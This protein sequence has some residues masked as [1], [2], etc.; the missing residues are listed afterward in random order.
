MVPLQV[1]DEEINPALS[2]V[3]AWK[4]PKASKKVPGYLPCN[5]YS[6]LSALHL[7]LTR[8]QADTPVKDFS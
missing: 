4:P 6:W 7:E 2:E 5:D 8:A 3:Q 1:N